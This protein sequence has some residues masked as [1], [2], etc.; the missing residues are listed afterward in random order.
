MQLE[1]LKLEME[2]LPDK[3][4]YLLLIFKDKEEEIRVGALGKIKFDMAYY[5]YVGSAQR[6]LRK[7]VE[8]HLRKEKKMKWHIDYLLCHS[9]IIDIFAK[10][11][12][13]SYEEKIAIKLGKKYSYIPNFGSSDSKA[14]S[15][16]FRI[17]RND[18]IA[19][20]EFLRDFK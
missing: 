14:P 17:E 5:V 15:H 6:N 1:Y 18:W 13:K 11:Y 2:R 20:K 4:I 7:R 12:P 8:R 16:L 9:K 10:N 3:G 19:I